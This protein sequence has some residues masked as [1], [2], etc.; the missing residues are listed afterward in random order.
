MPASM[1]FAPGFSQGLGF[2]G[3]DNDEINA[4]AYQLLNVGSLLESII[5]CILED[6]LDIGV[7]FSGGLHICIHLN[8][9][10]LAQLALGHADSVDFT[11]LFALLANFKHDRIHWGLLGFR[12]CVSASAS[13]DQHHARE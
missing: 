4:S 8:A 2:L 5:L 12:V 11:R 13:P 7:F 6:H 3:A 10:G 9:P 1:A